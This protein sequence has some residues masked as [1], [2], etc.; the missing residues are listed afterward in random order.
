MHGLAQSAFIDSECQLSGVQWLFDGPQVYLRRLLQSGAKVIPR[1][2][3]RASKDSG[4][5]NLHPTVHNLPVDHGQ[6]AVCHV[7]QLRIVC[8]DHEGLPESLP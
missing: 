6:L 2:R 3:I 8:D 4:C 7:G 1:Q 5:L